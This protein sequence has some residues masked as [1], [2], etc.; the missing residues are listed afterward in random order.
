[1]GKI[2]L[3]L[4]TKILLLVCTVV[5]IALLVVNIMIT[6]H[7]TGSVQNGLRDNAINIALSLP[8]ALA[9]VAE[10]FVGLPAVFLGLAGLAIAGGFVTWFISRNTVHFNQ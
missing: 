5:A 8:L 10:T 9:G 3:T 4:Q 1:M 2:Q 7:V 6:K